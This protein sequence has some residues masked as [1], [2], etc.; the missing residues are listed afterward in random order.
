VPGTLFQ[1][2]RVSRPDAVDHSSQIGIDDAIPLL[3]SEF[4]KRAAHADLGVVDHIVEVAETSLRG[5]N[6]VLDGGA[7]THVGHNRYS[8]SCQGPHLGGDCLQRSCLAAGQNYRET[9]IGKSPGH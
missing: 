5:I 4:L 7:I 3:G 6:Q 8:V 9:M 2:D 1:H